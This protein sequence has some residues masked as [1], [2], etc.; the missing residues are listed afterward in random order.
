MDDNYRPQTCICQLVWRL[1]AKRMSLATAELLTARGLHGSTVQ[2]RLSVC[3]GWPYAYLS[4]DIPI[5][6]S[7]AQC[8]PAKAGLG[9]RPGRLE[10]RQWVM[11]AMRTTL[12]AD[13]SPLAVDALAAGV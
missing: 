13:T 12:T 7:G 3:P 6:R 2:K 5:R 4:V 1:G 10:L 9:M 8:W 11:P